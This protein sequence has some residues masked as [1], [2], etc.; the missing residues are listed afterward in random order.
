MLTRREHKCL[1][2][3]ANGYL[4]KEVASELN[5]HQRTVEA[6]LN[7]AREKL[8]SSTTVQAVARAIKLGVIHLG[9]ISVVLLTLWTLVANGEA[10]LRPSRISRDIIVDSGAPETRL[11]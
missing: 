1:L 10:E 7:S 11:I 3:R 2:M 6:H 9:E 8:N 5:I 4:S